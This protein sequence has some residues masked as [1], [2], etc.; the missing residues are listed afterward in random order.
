MLR[1]FEQVGVF[2]L[3][4]AL[5]MALALYKMP[6]IQLQSESRRVFEILIK[7]APGCK[8]FRMSQL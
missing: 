3:V 8:R 5:E 2:V 7:D 1:C 4:Q 6:L